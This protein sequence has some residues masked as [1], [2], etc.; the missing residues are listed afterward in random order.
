MRLDPVGGGELSSDRAGLLHRDPQLDPENK[1]G[2]EL[3]VS[4]S[5]TF[6]LPPD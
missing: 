2:G 6:I 4:Y 3:L 5:L 1:D